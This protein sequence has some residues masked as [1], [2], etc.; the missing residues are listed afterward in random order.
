MI[1]SLII[2]RSSMDRHE[3][4]CSSQIHEMREELLKR[5]ERIVK[6]LEFS[7][8]THTEFLE[9]PVFQDL[10][11][12]VKSKNRSWSKIWFYDTARVS[13]NRLKAQA[14]KAFLKNHEVTVEFLKLPKTGI[15]A[16]DNVLEG[17]LE[18]FDQMLSDFSRAGAIR[19]QKQNIRD[20]YRAGGRPPFGYQLKKHSVAINRDKEEIYKTTLVPNPDTFVFAR[21]FL[22]R[23][24]RGESRRSICRDFME[25]GIKSP[26]GQKKWYSSSGKSIEENVLVY[27][28]ENLITKDFYEKFIK[29]IQE[30]YENYKAESLSDQVKHKKRIE[31]LNSQ[32]ANLMTLFSR[33]KIKAELIENQIAP[34]QEELEELEAKVIDISQI[35]E[36]LNVKID[37]YTSESIQQQLEKFEEMLNEDNM[38]EM[39]NLVRDFIYKITLYPK[40]D[41]KSKKWSRCVQIESY[42]RALTMIKVASPTGFEPVLP[43]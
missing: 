19:G 2:A 42:I 39:R 1:N 20:G 17:I 18:S 7:K 40:N 41:P 12:E 9:D 11:T 5:G 38:V 28:K 25:R 32:I 15:E 13:R 22:Q 21:E 6:V 23:R 36:V 30:Q 8:T 29:T 31:E 10:L 35:N 26:S 34:L 33:G 4:S 27:L 37:E 43:A 3:V 24:G 14:L 16:M